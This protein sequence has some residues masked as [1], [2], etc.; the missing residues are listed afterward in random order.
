MRLNERQRKWMIE[1]DLLLESG[2]FAD[3]SLQKIIDGVKGPLAEFGDVVSAA[4]GLVMTDINYLLKLTVFSVFLMNSDTR[5]KLK[6]EK[7]NKRNKFLQ[8]VQKGWDTSGM[9]KDSKFMLTMLN[10]MAVFGGLGLATAAKPFDPEWR[11]QLGDMGFDMLPPPLGTMFDSDFKWDSPQIWKDISNAK[12][13]EEAMKILNAKM[14]GLLKNTAPPPPTGE[15]DTTTLG[16]PNSALALTGLFLLASEGE[17]HEGDILLEGDE[18]PDLT[19]RD[20]DLLRKWIYKTVQE[21]F[22]VPGEDLL[23]LK[24]KELKAYIGDIPK[25]VEAVSII[26]AATSKDAFLKGLDSLKKVL[27]EE[28]SKFD[29]EKVKNAFDQAKQAIKDDEESMKKLKKKFEEAKEEPSEQAVDEELDN[30]ALSGFKGKFLMQVKEALEKLLENTNE[31]IWDGMTK[32][33][34]KIVGQTETGK[35]YIQL[36]KKYEKQID[37]G[38]SKLKQT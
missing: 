14:D 26:S 31:E 6:Q 15:Q 18:S 7:E 25:A 22:K 33:E 35:A 27:G 32:S 13:D 9:D 11:T 10:P 2:S 34:I 4:V 8:R 37:D 12:N 17:E 24:E 1:N 29:T 20:Y 38:L 23:K 36:C 21:N 30:I 3:G 5:A 19:D 28:A 16:I